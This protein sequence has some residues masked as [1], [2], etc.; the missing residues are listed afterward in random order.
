MINSNQI[1]FQTFEA[2][3]DNK[4]LPINKKISLEY[5]N[6]DMDGIFENERS[7]RSFVS[8]NFLCESGSCKPSTIK[9]WT[10]SEEEYRNLFVVKVGQDKFINVSPDD[11]SL[12]FQFELYYNR[13][14][15]FPSAVEIFVTATIKG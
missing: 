15:S 13:S 6:F 4:F 1:T 12:E 14:S 8:G 7:W 3:E 5:L 9:N 10:Y 11:I 2:I